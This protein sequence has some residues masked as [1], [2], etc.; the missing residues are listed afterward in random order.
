MKRISI[1]LILLCCYTVSYT[2]AQEIDSL[3]WWNPEQSTFP[4]IEG[5]GWHEELK[6]TYDRL[7]AKAEGVV[8][9]NVWALSRY[10]AGLMIRFRSNSGRIKIRYGVTRELHGRE[11][12]PAT[13]V[14]GVDLYAIDSDGNWMWTRGSR[15]FSDTIIY[16]FEGISQN[17]NY[18]AL[19]REYRLYLPLYNGVEWMEIGVEEN[20][21]FRPLPVR[22][23]KPIVIYGTSIAH[24]ACATRPGMAWTS[25]LGRK[26][27]RPVINLGFAGNGRLDTEV[28]DFLTELD[29]KVYIFDCLPNLTG[30]QKEELEKRIKNCVTLLKD[31]KPEVPIVLSDHAGYTDGDLVSKRKAIYE[32]VNNIQQ[33]TYAKL[34][35]QGINELF[36][37][38][39][40]EL[41]LQM[42]DMVDG[43]HPNDLGMQHYAEGYEKALRVIMKE[44]TG[45]ASTTHPCIQYREPN[46]YDWED[47]H[48]DILEMNKVSAPKIAFIA[49]SIIHFWGGEPRTKIVTEAGSW[50]TIFTPMGV[51]NFA[52]GWD[53]LENVLWR[54]Y[55][56]EL[57]GF[58]ADKVAMMIGTNNLH[59]NTDEEIIQGLEYIIK[60]IMSRQSTA[61]IL[62]FGLLPRRDLEGRVEK[63]NRS[64]S[65]LAGL[66]N[67]EY[68]DIGD[69]FLKDSQKIDEG[70][71][72]D[73]LHPNS[74]GYKRMAIV[75]EPILSD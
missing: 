44:P 54:I 20:S 61:K 43:T 51:R 14:S 3:K 29:A 19:G 1:F 45:T 60:G 55:H 42:D 39:K 73:G 46:N 35:T 49:N 57:D 5:Q 65:Q 12:M 48:R 37:I 50:E 13:G 59:L 52:Y 30:V 23:E 67:V 27:D 32:N 21:F 8:S 15:T 18:H 16:D 28:V 40:A 17:G 68:N 11:Y 47:R 74:E 56:D 69:I 53:R 9:D 41:G 72:S 24:G 34:K 58:E 64:I 6:S 7:P 63:L 2:A 66:L 75:L 22:M 10:S 31:F 33:A 4:V 71:F 62:L 36:Y 25:I 26:L 70:L 38:T